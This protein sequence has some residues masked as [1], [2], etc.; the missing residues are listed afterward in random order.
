MD[1]E[2][3]APSGSVAQVKW[4]EDKSGSLMLDS[5]MQAD[6]QPTQG[7]PRSVHVLRHKVVLAPDVKDGRTPPYMHHHRRAES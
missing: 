4:L 1:S 2:S 6:G 3:E 5:L 7:M